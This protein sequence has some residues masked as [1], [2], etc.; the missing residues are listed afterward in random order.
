MYNMWMVHGK[1][2]FFNTV[3]ALFPTSA[4]ASAKADE[5]PLEWQVSQ[6]RVEIPW[7]I[8]DENVFTPA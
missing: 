2:E 5:H 7:I 6:I 3:I 1:G 8:I 4:A